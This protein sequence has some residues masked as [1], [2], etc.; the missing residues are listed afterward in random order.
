MLF[1]DLSTKMDSLE[2]SGT[3]NTA[4]DTA[5]QHANEQFCGWGED[6]DLYVKGKILPLIHGLMSA[7]IALTVSGAILIAGWFWV[8]NEYN[9]VVDWM[10]LNKAALAGASQEKT[11]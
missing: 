9:K 11:G 5:R 8:R 7:T 10:A 4:L 6:L 1:V 3:I 2:N